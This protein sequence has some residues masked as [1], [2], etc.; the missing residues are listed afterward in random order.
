MFALFGCFSENLRGFTEK[1]LKK[2][3]KKEKSWL[4]KNLKEKTEYLTKNNV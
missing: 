1:M 3:L 4:R 2:G